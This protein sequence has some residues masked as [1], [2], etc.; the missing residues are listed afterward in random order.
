MMRW[1]SRAGTLAAMALLSACDPSTGAGGEGRPAAR[2]PASRADATATPPFAEVYP[3]AVIEGTPTLAGGANGQGGMVTF[4]TSA[5]PQTVVDFYKARAGEAGLQSN[6]ALNQ[7]DA[8][9]Y[10]AIAANGAMVQVVAAP[11]EGGST[12]VQLSWS[13]GS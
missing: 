7:G 2:A 4:T 6:M 12:S 10:G 5:G 1:V 8:V 9:A 13:A 3:G 11:V